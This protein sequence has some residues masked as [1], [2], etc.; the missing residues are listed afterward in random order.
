MISSGSELML[1]HDMVFHCNVLN[2]LNITVPD[3]S[4]VR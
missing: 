2:H 3:K 1:L 4:C